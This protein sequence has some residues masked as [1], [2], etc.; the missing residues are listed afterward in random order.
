M[1]A[2]VGSRGGKHVIFNQCKTT[3]TKLKWRM[4]YWDLGE[5]IQEEGQ[6]REVDTNSLSSEPLLQVLRHG[7]HLNTFRINEIFSS[8]VLVFMTSHCCFC[9]IWR[10]IL[11]I[12]WFKFYSNSESFM[13]K[14]HMY[15]CE[16]KKKKVI[17]HIGHFHV[18]GL[19]SSSQGRH[20]KLSI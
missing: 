16:L 10:N 1:S 7:D 17:G 9:C 6:H 4:T 15:R 2:C 19:A 11:E 8:N 3:G 12:K 13:K 18:C 14:S 5:N 20:I